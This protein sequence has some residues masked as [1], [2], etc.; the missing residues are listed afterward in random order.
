M[1][2]SMLILTLVIC[3]LVTMIATS[4]QFNRQARKLDEDYRNELSAAEN[5]EGSGVDGKITLKPKN[6]TGSEQKVDV[7][8]YSTPGS[9]LKSYRK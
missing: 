7:K 1:L 9:E 5:F 8:I 3:L 2:V 6:F 4:Y